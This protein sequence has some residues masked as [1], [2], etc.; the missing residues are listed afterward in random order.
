[1]QKKQS[2]IGKKEGWTVCERLKERMELYLFLKKKNETEEVWREENKIRNDLKKKKESESEGVCVKILRTKTHWSRSPQPEHRLS[3]SP[4]HLEAELLPLQHR[5]PQLSEKPQKHV[6]KN[7]LL[8]AFS[9]T[10]SFF[11]SYARLPIYSSNSSNVNKA[12]FV[13]KFLHKSSGQFEKMQHHEAE[14]FLLQEELSVTCSEQEVCRKKTCH[15][16]RDA[17]VMF[18]GNWIEWIWTVTD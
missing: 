2:V 9:Q 7:T 13:F 10:R 4:S 8:N 14:M 3:P 16:T 18:L 15:V 11:S 6:F 5:V 12:F 1:M 17:A